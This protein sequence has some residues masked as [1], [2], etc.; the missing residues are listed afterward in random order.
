M[1]QEKKQ[2]IKY[3]LWINLVFGIQNLYFYV[4]ND[5]LINLTIGA[6]NVGVWVFFRK[7]AK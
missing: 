3:I 4:N 5:S 2:F 7:I 1:T 6:L